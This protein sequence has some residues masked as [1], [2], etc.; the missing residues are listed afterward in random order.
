MTRHRWLRIAAAAAVIAAVTAPAAAQ[1][2]GLEARVEALAAQVDELRELAV[3]APPIAGAVESLSEAVAELEHE[4]AALRREQQAIPDAIDVIDELEAHTREL[5]REIGLLRA[6]LADLEQ[7]ILVRPGDGSV[8]RDDGF[9]WETD[10]G[11]Y[12][13]RL[14]GLVQPRYQLA[15]AEGYDEVEAQTLTLRRARLGVRGHVTSPSWRYA[16]ELELQDRRP[17]VEARVDYEID[18]ALVL[19]AGQYKLPHT[20]SFLMREGEL[21][22]AE[23]PR[24]VEAV[25]YDREMAASAY[26]Q[27][28]GGRLGYHGGVANGTGRNAENVGLDLAGFARVDGVVFGDRFGYRIADVEAGRETSLMIGGSL[29][30]EVTTLP[31]AVGGVP[32][33][34]ID[35]DADG[36]RDAIDVTSASVDAALAHRGLDVTLEAV[37]RREDWGTILDHPDNAA[38]AAWVGRGVEHYFGGYGQVTYAAWPERLVVG[39]RVGRVE[40]PLLGVSG[41]DPAAP[42][43]ADA[44]PDVDEVWEL[45][46][47]GSL[48]RRG[49]AIL[50]LDYTYLDH[51]VTG[52]GPGHRFILEAQLEL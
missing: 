25:R 24:A 14:W 50:G 6:Q 41:R 16:V 8:T 15:I 23:R 48:Y 37:W 30:H 46:V 28:L 3:Q 20:R 38:L 43:D 29:V 1:S 52:G 42:R 49:A 18:E 45:G 26:G 17:L 13:L 32:V 51:D 21:G 31:D 7:P 5:E 44:P 12:A 4:L 36:D 34:N 9:F 19:R 27:I 40:Q 2:Q 39:A 47:M 11:D 10:D 22:F 35:V 33:G